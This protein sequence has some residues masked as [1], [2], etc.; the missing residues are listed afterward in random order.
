MSTCQPPFKV[1]DLCLALGWELKVLA[2]ATI[3]FRAK[4][5][6]QNGEFPL[7]FHDS[8]AQTCA[9]RFCERD[10]KRRPENAFFA[11]TS[12]AIRKG[13]LYLPDDREK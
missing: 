13:E 6:L 5:P 8:V 4:F 2:P 10:E 3:R 7:D 11:K 12:E 1:N 9:R